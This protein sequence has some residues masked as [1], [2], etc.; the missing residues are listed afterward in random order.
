M[1]TDFDQRYRALWIEALL[2]KTKQG[3]Q[4]PL[5]KCTMIGFMG[6]MLA[7]AFATV[8]DQPVIPPV[9]HLPRYSL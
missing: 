4:Q 5:A 9:V 3:Y 6:S 2:D 1:P 8:I 7:S